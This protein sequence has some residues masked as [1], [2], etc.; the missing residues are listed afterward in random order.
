LKGYIK[1]LPFIHLGR[2]NEWHD[3]KEAD[4]FTIEIKMH[5]GNQKM[6][7]LVTVV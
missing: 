6:T 5:T 2:Q 1:R 4:I 7:T 3:E